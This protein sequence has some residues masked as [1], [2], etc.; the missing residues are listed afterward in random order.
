M[1]KILFITTRNPYSGR[2]SG[3]VIGSLKI[4]NF[5]KEKGLE[6][7]YIPKL[8]EEVQLRKN[9]NVSTGGDTIEMFEQVPQFYKDVAV[10]AT[11]ALGVN[12]CGIDLIVD[13]LYSKDK[14]YTI[15]EANFNPAIQMH[16]YPLVG[17]GKTPA[18]DILILLNK[19]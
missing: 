14:D 19:K 5:L 4:I 9:S 11:K 1:K 16:T 18:K 3:D 15:I 7:D 2:F 6:K 12:I 8:N 13:D 17:Y 10:K